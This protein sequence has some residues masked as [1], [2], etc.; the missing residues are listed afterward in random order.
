[1]SFFFSFLS[2]IID[3]MKYLPSLARAIVGINN[4]LTPE[5]WGYQN[6]TPKVLFACRLLVFLVGMVKSNL[7][8]EIS[9]LVRQ[10]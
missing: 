2:S 3:I 1:M 5:I 7:E 8:L 6:K 9:L 10:N 4:I